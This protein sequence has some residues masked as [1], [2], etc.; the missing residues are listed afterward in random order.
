MTSIG[1]SASRSRRDLDEI[2]P[3]GDLLELQRLHYDTANSTTK[4]TIEALL[5]LVPASQVLFGS[6]YPYYTIAENAAGLAKLGLSGAAKRAIER[7]NAQRLMPRLK[8]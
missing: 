1:S 2:A 7:G 6:D 8:A 4:S 3:H 5:D